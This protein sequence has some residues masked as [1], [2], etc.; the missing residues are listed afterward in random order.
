MTPTIVRLERVDSSM[1]ALHRLA[2]DG[3]EAGTVVVAAEQSG[4]RGSRGRRWASPPGGVWCSL[5]FRPASAA[6]LELAGLRAGLTVAETLD[7]LG[8]EPKL[9]LKWPND[10]MLDDRK[11]GGILCEARWQATTLEWLA[12]G[13]GLN[14]ENQ[15]PAGLATTAV[16]V[17]RY[18]PELT[19][20]RLLPPLIERLR[21]LDLE[22]PELTPEE[23]A[24]YAS[25]DW[26]RG[27]A[28]TAPVAG[29]AERVAADG[30]LIVRGDA[31]VATVRVGTIELAGG[32]IGA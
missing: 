11:A 15:I 2:E 28:L 19:V 25:R 14:L 26:L 3:A 8:L 32:P 20:E 16:A 6:G 7:R 5:L 13:L 10:L 30:A 12:V 29:I 27:R 1:D 23:L 31:A 21:L 24:S 18:L 4:G 9:Q 22:T 17:G